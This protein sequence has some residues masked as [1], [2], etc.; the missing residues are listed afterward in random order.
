MIYYANPR[1]L[2]FLAALYKK[3]T[4]KANLLH[5]YYSLTKRDCSSPFVR[6]IRLGC[7]TTEE[8]GGPQRRNAN[9]GNILCTQHACMTYGRKNAAFRAKKAFHRLLE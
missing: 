5:K 8:L 2:F 3:P 4:N 7:T 9:C 1:I 6:S